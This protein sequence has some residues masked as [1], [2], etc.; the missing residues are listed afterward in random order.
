MRGVD[1]L[2]WLV[3]HAHGLQHDSGLVNH[4][5]SA[6]NHSPHVRPFPISFLDRR[7]PLFC[8]V[9][10]SSSLSSQPI[11]YQVHA[12][13]EKVFRGISTRGESLQKH[14]TNSVGAMSVSTRQLDVVTGSQRKDSSLDEETEDEEVKINCVGGV[15]RGYDGDSDF[16]DTDDD[17][18]DKD[19]EH[20]DEE[21]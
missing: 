10:C 4:G 5:F 11:H 9:Q 12:T 8:Q 18:D 19:S 2:A 6:F 17:G 16:W 20:E 14:N 3:P 1:G 15:R 21:K 7:H 13:K